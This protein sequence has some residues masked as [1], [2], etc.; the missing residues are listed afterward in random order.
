VPSLRFALFLSLLFLVAKPLVA[1]TYYVGTCKTGAFTTISAAVAAVPAGSIV[2]VC[3]GFY[4]EQVA[5]T[6]PLTLH[7]LRIHGSSQAMITMPAGG[8]ATTR[9]IVSGTVAAQVEVR[10]ET[11]NIRN[12]GVNGYTASNCPKTTHIGIF[13]SSRSSGTVSEVSILNQNCNAMGIGLLAENSGTTEAVTIANSS[14]QSFT[15][16]GITAVCLCD[17]NSALTASV[18]GNYVFSPESSAL[19]GIEMQRVPGSISGNVVSV[20]LSTVAIAADCGSESAD[21]GSD[22][23]VTGNT[24]SGGFDGVLMLRAGSVIGNTITGSAM[25]RIQ[26]AIV[27]FRTANVIVEHNNVGFTDYGIWLSALGVTKAI[28]KS[29]VITNSDVGI[30]FNC[31]AGDLTVSGN[32]INVAYTG[33]DAVPES[34]TGANKFYNV[35]TIRNGA[36]CYM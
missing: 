12:I 1:E 17:Q 30:E 21:C 35:A 36:A 19:V 27:L 9:S 20:G 28:V 24:L 11:V 32:T 8:L 2:A 18:T 7:G 29:N 33:M 14:I 6:K 13:Y 25:T 4:A 31:S 22:F 16:F 34:F 15:K 5:I 26:Y 10:A 23:S 3:P